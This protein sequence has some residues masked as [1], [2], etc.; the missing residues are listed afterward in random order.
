MSKKIVITNVDTID[1]AIEF[2]NAYPG[3]FGPDERECVALYL[4][5]KNS[6]DPLIVECRGYIE[7]SIID[8]TSNRFCTLRDQ[9]YISKEVVLNE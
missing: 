3:Y 2:M 6:K 5:I 8:E 4:K 1:E 9:H 7:K